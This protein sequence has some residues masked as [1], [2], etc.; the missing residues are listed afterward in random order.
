MILFITENSIGF[1]SCNSLE[2]TKTKIDKNGIIVSI[3]KLINLEIFI[4]IVEK[5][6]VFYKGKQKRFLLDSI[7]KLNL[8]WAEFSDKLD[9]SRGTL[10]K[11]Y[12]YEFCSLPYNVF[13]D[14][15]NI[16]K[17]K[18]STIIKLYNAKVI[19]FIP[20]IGR[21]CLGEKRT[22]LP[23]IKI[24]FDSKLPAFDNSIIDLS[25]YDKS[26]KLKLPKKLTP[27]LAEEI[28]IHVGDGFLSRR[29]NEYRL[30]GNKN[31]E[32]EYY[33]NFIKPLYKKLYNLDVNIKEY[34][35]TYGFELRSR[36]FWI[37]KNKILKI[38]AGRKDNMK[39]PEVIK[40]ND[41]GI[42]TSFIR[43]VFDTDGSVSFISKYGFNNYYPTIS[44]AMLSE[45]L[46]KGISEILQMLGLKPNTYKD[47]RGYSSININGYQR[48][49]KYLELI[50]SNNPKHLSKIKGWKKLYPNLAK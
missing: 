35:T 23:E 10:E 5:R 9:V 22:N 16:L 29:R 39:V 7:E 1:N 40:V 15:C 20:V 27:D 30:K 8:K 13:R 37:F 41:I 33:N 44:I 38:P 21:K 19:F 18:E 42:L 24:Q 47:K 17:Q 14:I 6:V 50:G 3:E 43:G 12:R 48:L 25:T 4:V 45:D 34:E 11:S 49:K 31:D 46:I 36:G 32:K 26:K 28:G 2:K